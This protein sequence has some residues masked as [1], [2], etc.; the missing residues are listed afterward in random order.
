MS[1]PSKSMSHMINIL[2]LNVLNTIVGCYF[3]FVL[4]LIFDSSHKIDN[5]TKG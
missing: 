3:F 4:N 2:L 1:F 5:E